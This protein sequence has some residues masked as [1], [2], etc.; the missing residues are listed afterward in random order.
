M[1]TGIAADID[2]QFHHPGKLVV[3]VGKFT[4][5]SE[6]VFQVVGKILLHQ[7]DGGGAQ[8]TGRDLAALERIDNGYQVKEGGEH[9]GGIEIIVHEIVEASELVSDL[10]VQRGVAGG[11]GGGGVAGEF[12]QQFE[13]FPKSSEAFF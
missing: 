5:Q 12:L 6:D 9:F 8:R 4:F 7:A 10:V 2:Q 1:G 13:G 3:L 11:G